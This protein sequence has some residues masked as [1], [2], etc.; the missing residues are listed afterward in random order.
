MRQMPVKCQII[1][2]F[3]WNIHAKGLESRFFP[4]IIESMQREPEE[5]Q[6]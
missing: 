3:G 5:N 6:P 1:L 4:V 2:F